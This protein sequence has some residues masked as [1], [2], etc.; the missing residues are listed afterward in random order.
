MGHD[1]VQ[2]MSV[3]GCDPKVSQIPRL[4]SRHCWFSDRRIMI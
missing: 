1:Q 4:I 2:I 3:P